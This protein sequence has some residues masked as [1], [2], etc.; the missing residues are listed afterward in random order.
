MEIARININRDPSYPVYDVYIH[1]TGIY[2]KKVAVLAT[3]EAAIKYCKE[4]NLK[5]EVNL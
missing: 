4:N 5:C 2:W 3:L 1:D